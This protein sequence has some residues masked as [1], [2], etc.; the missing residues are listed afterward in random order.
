M[1]FKGKAMTI[2]E[3]CAQHNIM[4]NNQQMA[5][6]ESVN[7]QTL[8]LAVPGSG[9]TTVI[10]ARTGYMILCKNIPPKNILTVTYSKASAVDMKER[11][12]KVFG[13]ISEN[14][15]FKTIH[16]LCYEI[17][18]YLS[19]SENRKSFDMIKEKEVNGIIRGIYS[20]MKNNKFLQENQLKD[21]KSM[22]TYSVNMMLTDEEIND[23]SDEIDFLE[24]FQKFKKCKTQ[25]KLMDYD[26]QLLFAYN[27]L[28]NNAN[29]RNHFQNKYKYV[30]VDEA[31]DTSKIQH[32]IIELLVSKHKNI[33]MVGD[34][35]QTIYGF[36]AAFPEALLK[37]KDIYKDGTV[38][39]MEQN[40]RSVQ[41]IVKQ[42]NHFIKDNKSRY[43]KNMF[44]ENS[45]GDEIKH[46][47]LKD[48]SK[49]YE[50]LKN[51]AENP[52]CQTAIL[53]RNNESAI[54]IIDM[55]Q[56]NNIDFYMREHDSPFFN[57]FIVND[58]VNIINFSYDFNNS[59]IFEKIY[60]KFGIGIKKVDMLTIKK[61]Y[62]NYESIFHALFEMY[63]EDWRKV[64]IIN[65]YENFKKLPLLNSFNAL[66]RIFY[67]M[68]YNEYL[69]NK[70]SSDSE[71]IFKIKNVNVSY[72]QKTKT[73]LSL[74]K[75]NPNI[76]EFLG[77]LNEL[78]EITN[79]TRK[80]NNSIIL[81]TIHSSKG[82][83]YD[84]V[85]LIDLVDGIFPQF[86]RDR[87]PFLDTEDRKLLEEDRRL[88]YVAVTRAKK[89]LE[90]LS[91]RKE[92]DK[93]IKI[94]YFTEKLLSKIPTIK[95]IASEKPI[96]KTIVLNTSTKKYDIFKK[97]RV[98]NTSPIEEIY[99][100]FQIGTKILHNAYGVG[101]ITE[102]NK[103]I[104][105][106]KF[107]TGENRKFDM[108]ICILNGIVKKA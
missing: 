20:E 49:Q 98:K 61:T 63:D 54:P 56:K 95:P 75:Q 79:Q 70:N 10:V 43:D 34:E 81:S 50:Y 97:P 35:D 22:L 15:E 48:Y 107:E 52:K 29:V 24:F 44:T 78:Y 80:K 2:T 102:I 1:I 87:L 11:F 19:I 74:A 76:P 86:E 59:D 53:F 55:L 92:F 16:S 13:D 68:G 18:R 94:S 12:H 101:I 23:L 88:F 96:E 28:K 26:D 32:K 3:F 90:I 27:L 65:L 100:D 17:I 108:S 31:Q 4:L 57:H 6:V 60:Y 51:I 104:Y 83:E 69:N 9:K 5:A 67:Q 39:K 72:A 58:I 64:K 77:R 42:A 62:R 71:E 14:I 66:N 37:F 46:T 30:S 91:Y 25:N 38:L 41:N 99:R 33:F 85:I 103:T 7:G 40:Y 82:L 105:T 36:R 84:K 73:L 21:I 8:L 93:S 89:E 106:V 47:I 45:V